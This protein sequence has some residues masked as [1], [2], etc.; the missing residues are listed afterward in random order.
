[1][2]IF[3][4]LITTGVKTI[5]GA[6]F[7]AILLGVISGGAVL[8]LSY[9]NEHQ[10]H[11]QSSIITYVI[12]VFIAVLMAYATATT[13]FLSAIAKG[14]MGVTK[15]IEDDAEKAVTGHQ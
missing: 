7:A 14:V 9:I 4:Q 3:S 5:A 2:Q 13:A 11:W 15:S 8:G 10:A 1:M 6:F 12:A